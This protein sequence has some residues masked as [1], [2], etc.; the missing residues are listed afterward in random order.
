MDYGEPTDLIKCE[1]CQKEA[2]AEDW[3]LSNGSCL[4]NP[5]ALAVEVVG[6][7]PDKS[8]VS[9]GESLDDHGTR[10]G[11]G[12]EIKAKVWRLHFEPRSVA[13]AARK[14][15]TSDAYWEQ[16]YQHTRQQRMTLG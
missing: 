5:V 12:T 15:R 11:W 14:P 13:I 7:P 16:L 6:D 1:S 9:E 8:L 3:R 10:R 2:S 4:G